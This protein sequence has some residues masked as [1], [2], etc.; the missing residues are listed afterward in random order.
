MDIKLKNFPIQFIVRITTF[1][2]PFSQ[3]SNGYTY[4]HIRTPYYA[5]RNG[6]VYGPHQVT[7]EYS[8]YNPCPKNQITQYPYF[9]P[10][11]QYQNNFKNHYKPKP[12]QPENLTTINSKS[13]ATLKPIVTSK[14][15]NHQTF[16]TQPVKTPQ[17]ALGIP[18]RTYG[19]RPIMQCENLM[20][21]ISQREYFKAKRIINQIN[22]PSQVPSSKF[23]I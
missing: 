3:G 10:S 8:F 18:R 19:Y 6:Y 12:K 15:Q 17:S 1:V 11:H 5:T 20:S 23:R 13:Y 9:N 22:F 4:T 14:V 2:F 21:S 16:A 7:Q